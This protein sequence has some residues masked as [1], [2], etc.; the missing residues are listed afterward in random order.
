MSVGWFRSCILSKLASALE[1]QAEDALESTF[2]PLRC[3]A[4]AA[5]ACP[6]KE[7]RPMKLVRFRPA[8]EEI[9]QLGVYW[10]RPSMPS[11]PFLLWGGA[12]G[13]RSASGS[14]RLLGLV[15]G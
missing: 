6:L 2:K 10:E 14:S 5:A 11:Y 8:G 9:A 7:E 12:P 3:G 13:R 1:A 4:A 15:L